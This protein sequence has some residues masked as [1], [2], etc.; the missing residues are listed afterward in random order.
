M[1]IAFLIF[2]GIVGGLLSGMLG[3]GG[4]IFYILIFPYLM[5]SHG[6]PTEAI[7]QY[8]I[9]NSIF[10]IM[11]ASSFSVIGY[12][13]I[14]IFP[15]KE[16]FTF[17]I[18]AAV[19]A[20]LSLN[21]IVMQPWYSKTVFNILVIFL[22][23]YILFQLYLELKVKKEENGQINVKQSIVGGSLSGFVSVLSG[24]GGGIIIIPWLS[25]RYK[26]PMVKA[27]II[28]L[29]TILI[30]SISV[31]VN[32]LLSQPSIQPENML[33]IGYIIPSCVVPITIGSLVGSNLGIKW[34]SKIKRIYLDLL[35]IFFVV[36]VLLEKIYGLISPAY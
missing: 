20:Q 31:T 30:S 24:L 6:I 9:A 15:R 11:I 36:L 17:G 1:E 5:F 3:V 2:L 10:A 35:F 13:K 12:K 19:V 7:P 18:S 8:V 33:T 34:S 32:N 25:I 14:G 4:G 28:S 16:I 22:M 23:F 29:A 26:I 27:K 21:F